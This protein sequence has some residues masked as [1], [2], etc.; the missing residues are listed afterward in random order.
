MLS[1]RLSRTSGGILA[2]RSSTD[3]TP[4]AASIAFWS[5]GVLRTY[6]AILGRNQVFGAAG[7]ERTHSRKRRAISANANTHVVRQREQA[8]E[9][10]EREVGIARLTD[11][12]RYEP[13][14]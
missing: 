12:S 2:N 5:S 3:E 6:T 8:R 1:G 10:R 13:S 9:I 11:D 14:G 7:S 4:I